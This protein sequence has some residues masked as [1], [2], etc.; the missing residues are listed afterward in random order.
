MGRGL[1]SVALNFCSPSLLLFISLSFPVS[2]FCLKVLVKPPTCPQAF[3]FQTLSC[4]LFLWPWQRHI[5]RRVSSAESWSHI[6]S[7][8][9]SGC[10]DLKQATTAAETLRHTERGF[11]TDT[12]TDLF[13]QRH[14]SLSAVVVYCMSVSI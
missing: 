14:E 5:I 1:P 3:I 10:L 6:C 2:C 7:G 12:D 4:F 13:S 11:H 9:L 8:G